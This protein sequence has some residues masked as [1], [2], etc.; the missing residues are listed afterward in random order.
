MAYT[1][2]PFDYQR[3][4][5]PQYDSDMSAYRTGTAGSPNQGYEPNLNQ[6]NQEQNQAQQNAFQGY[7]GDQFKGLFD[8]MNAMP[9]NPNPL[10]GFSQAP[11]YNPYRGSREDFTTGGD[12][13][14]LYRSVWD[15]DANSQEGGY[16][17]QPYAGTT[18]V[19][20]DQ[21]GYLDARFGNINDYLNRM[22]SFLG[23]ISDDPSGIAVRQA[24]VQRAIQQANMPQAGSLSGY[25]GT[26][27]V[28]GLSGFS[29][30]APGSNYGGWGGRQ[31]SGG[32]G[33]HPVVG[34]LLG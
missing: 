13:T 32:W 23:N 15:N 14:T 30:S 9:K 26:P 31:V 20:F 24:E 10:S 33:S 21:K 25:G 34:G 3:A 28:G 27:Q 17:N 4:T 29:Q 7:A 19:N 11:R 6:W 16:V 22:G 8:M 18:P 2:T 1:Y 5:A 12:P